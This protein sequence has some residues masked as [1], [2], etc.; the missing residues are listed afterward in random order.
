MCTLPVYIRAA[1]FG[2]NYFTRNVYISILLSIEEHALSMSI[3]IKSRHSNGVIVRVPELLYNNV[4]YES[5]YTCPAVTRPD[6]LYRPDNNLT[7]E[8]C[9]LVYMASLK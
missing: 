5:I 7:C 9:F 4:W 1:S 2:L 6:I 8:S 3:T